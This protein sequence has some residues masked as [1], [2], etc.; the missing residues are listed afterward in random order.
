MTQNQISFATLEESRRHNAAEESLKREQNKLTKKMNAE[1][2]KHYSRQDEINK[3]HYERSDASGSISAQANLISA[4]A[5]ALN[6]STNRKNYE[7][8]YDIEYGWTGDTGYPKG[9]PLSA[10]RKNMDLAQSAGRYEYEISALQSEAEQRKAQALN[11][12]LN[13]FVGKGGVW[14]VVSDVLDLKSLNNN[15]LD[16]EN[17][18]QIGTDLIY[19][20]P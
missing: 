18:Y 7:M 3:S 17:Y 14:G 1:T 12:V 4:N 15:K 13:A 5:S 6:A 2:A 10:Q 8:A 11:S 20:G 19:T 9:M 16:P